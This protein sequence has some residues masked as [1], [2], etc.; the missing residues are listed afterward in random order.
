MV[1]L[2]LLCSLHR[3]PVFYLHA[4]VPVFDLRAR[5]CRR[6]PSRSYKTPNKLSHACHGG[7]V[8]L[9]IKSSR[10]V[11]LKINGL[12]EAI[13]KKKKK[14][15]IRRT[16]S[17]EVN[18]FT[19]LQPLRKTQLSVVNVPAIKIHQLTNVIMFIIC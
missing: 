17:D 11:S 1:L 14:N 8:V 12:W 5:L 9:E 18:D 15:C 7:W 6:S 13:Q 10:I 2:L 3:V 19:I 4:R 16:Y